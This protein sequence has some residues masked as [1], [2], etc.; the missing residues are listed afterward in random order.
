M[1]LT[2]RLVLLSYEW[3]F[4]RPRIGAATAIAR[5]RARERFPR[6][7]QCLA[8]LHGPGR[9]V[10]FTAVLVLASLYGKKFGVLTASVIGQLRDLHP[11]LPPQSQVVFLNDPFSDWDMTFIG[12][13]WF[14]DRS[15]HVYNQA[16]EH[17]SPVE[18]A[19]MDAVFD[20]RDGRLLQ[21]E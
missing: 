21:L 20:F 7:R 6:T 15:I 3:T 18:L 17:L 8:W 5:F 10:L 2:M 13:L 12:M 14:A 9:L 11:R 4:H 1:A 16:H 19:R